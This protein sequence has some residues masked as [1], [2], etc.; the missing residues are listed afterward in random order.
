MSYTINNSEDS[1]TIAA[2]NLNNNTEAQRPAEFF[3]FN[4]EP[5]FQY[6]GQ[7]R[8]RGVNCGVL[9]ALILTA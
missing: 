6:V 1:C 4:L 7:K 3:T 5:Q 9:R 8:A 2:L